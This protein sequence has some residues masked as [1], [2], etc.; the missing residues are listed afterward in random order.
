MKKTILFISLTTFFLLCSCNGESSSKDTIHQTIDETGTAR[1]GDLNQNSNSS[2]TN[3]V[4]DSTSAKS[5]LNDGSEN[6]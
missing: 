4:Q 3:T 2:G 5:N 1:D 6:H